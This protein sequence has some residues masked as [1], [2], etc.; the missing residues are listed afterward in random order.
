MEPWEQIGV[1]KAALQ[2]IQDKTS[3]QPRDVLE[4]QAMQAAVNAIAAQALTDVQQR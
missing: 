1:L 4:G 3:V 2:R